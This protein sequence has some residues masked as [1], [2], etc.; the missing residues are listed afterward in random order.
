MLGATRASFCFRL[1]LSRNGRLR[2]MLHRQHRFQLALR[3]IIDTV[4][5]HLASQK[6]IWCDSAQRRQWCILCCVVGLSMLVRAMQAGHSCYI[7]SVRR[8]PQNIM[9]NVNFVGQLQTHGR[10]TP[11]V[12]TTLQ[13]CEHWYYIW[14]GATSRFLCQHATNPR[15]TNAALSPLILPS[16]PTS[17]HILTLVTFKVEYI[18]VSVCSDAKN[19]QSDHV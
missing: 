4:V 10:L 3:T 9:W 14:S 11:V 16:A 7:K 13:F 15:Q 12:V 17:R 1:K 18:S 19:E 5:T 8:A 6:H 2:W